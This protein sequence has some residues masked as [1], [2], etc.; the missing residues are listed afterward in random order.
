VPDALRSRRP[1][2]AI[3]VYRGVPHRLDL[4]ACRLALVRCQV[5]GE[6]YSAEGLASAIGISRS[7]VSRFFGGRAT[8]LQ[9]TLAILEK[10]KL[11]FDDVAKP[12]ADLN[13]DAAP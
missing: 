12:C 13:P 11:R 2:T 5:E 3:V 10:L 8:S 6:F 1:R 9:T 4:V 7:T